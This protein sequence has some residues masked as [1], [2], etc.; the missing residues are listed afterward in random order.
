MRLSKRETVRY[1]I[2]NPLVIKF[3]GKKIAVV[4]SPF[5]NFKNK[6]A[7]D[8]LI[9]SGNPNILIGDIERSFSCKLLV[10]DSS[11]NPWKIK[12]WKEECEKSGLRYHSVV[13]SGAFVMNMD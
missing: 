1:E 13:D 12:K 10:F 9:I 6:L 5:P 4:E 7:V 8:L 2:V 3:Y 11:N